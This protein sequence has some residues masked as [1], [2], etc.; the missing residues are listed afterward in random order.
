MIPIK[1][2]DIEDEFSSDLSLEMRLR[3]YVKNHF[4]PATFISK[5]CP[6]YLIGGSIRDL[7]NAKG[8]KDMDFVVMGTKNMDFVLSVF[9]KLNIEYKINSL[10]GF[11]FTYNGMEID[12]W[13]TDDLFNSIEYNV[14]GLLYDIGNESLVSLTFSDFEKNGL[15]LVNP[16]NNISNGRVMK[17]E[18]FEEEYKR[19]GS[20]N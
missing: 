19:L 6:I 14:D 17:L 10:G 12:L 11:K 3:R 9:K 13:L 18:K 7:I 8:P 16:L 20:I 5:L 2:N 1:Y 4:Y 15:K